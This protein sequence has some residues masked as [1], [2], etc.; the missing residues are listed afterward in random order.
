MLLSST[1]I[2]TQPSYAI[3]GTGTGVA[4]EKF[5]VKRC[6]KQSYASNF[7]DLILNSNGTWSVTTQTGAYTGIWTDANP[8]KP[9]KIFNLAFDS[10]SH[11][12]FTSFLENQAAILCGMAPITITS[13]SIKTFIAK[14]N[15]KQSKIA[16]KLKVITTGTS[17][18]GVSK[19]KYALKMKANF[20]PSSNGGGGD[21]DGLIAQF[22]FDESLGNVALDISG[23]DNHGDVSAASRVNGYFG[24]G[25]LFGFNDAHVKLDSKE[26]SSLY[27]DAGLITID[28]WINPSTIEAGK[29]YRII[30]DY[31]YHGFYFQ[32]RDGRL[33][34]LFEGQSY[35]YGTVSIQPGVW[36]HIAFT[37]DG[38][39]II[40][41]V[42]GI[43]EAR[44]NITLPI[45]Y[46]SN[47]KI[48]AHWIYPSDYVE[49][50][51]GIIDELRIWDTARTSDEVIGDYNTQLIS[52][53]NVSLDDVAYWAALYSFDET[54]GNVANDD[55]GL[56]NHGTITA[57]TRMAGYSGNGLLFG[58]DDA[59]VTVDNTLYFDDGIIGIEAWI[60]PSTIEAGK[61]Y[62][63]IGDYNYHGFYFQ[64]RD[65]RLEVLFEGQ[66]Y[67]YGTV[68]IQPG[69]WTHIAFISDGKDIITF[70]D[71]IEDAQTNI[72]LPIRSISNVKIGAH[73]IYPSDYVEEFPGIIDELEIVEGVLILN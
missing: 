41:Y 48:G 13:L 29:V 51:P 25:L 46:I 61:V 73:W 34:V 37:S 33:E 16:V 57:A 32:I 67:H 2:L 54:S 56:D 20:T 59:R 47:V 22:S 19:G 4:K 11:T 60:N 24:E 9:D 45:Q 8:S 65:G 3:D 30:G 23:A 62:R 43:E 44:T 31:N 72:T 18:I 64:I 58:A 68:P 10:G 15:K 52:P 28:A 35:H 40:T 42:N 53:P 1:S 27:F 66:S 38:T 39:N 6:G 7:D 5:S 36:T 50:F 63:I 69:V 21:S 12:Q 26:D 49:E 70:I 17:P 71:G 55:S 14:A